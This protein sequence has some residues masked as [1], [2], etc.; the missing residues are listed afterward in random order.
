M[1][2]NV[3]LLLRHLGAETINKYT[4]NFKGNVLRVF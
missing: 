2:V 3:R 1:F 4:M